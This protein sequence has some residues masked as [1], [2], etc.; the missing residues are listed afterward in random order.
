MAT[1]TAIAMKMKMKT[2]MKKMVIATSMEMTMEMEI[3][4][5]TETAPKIL[6]VV[7]PDEPDSI[8]IPRIP[9]EM[10][11]YGHMARQ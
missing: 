10:H 8:T 3:Y 6:H 4:M 9:L 11:T 2:T 7:F 1:T 5:E